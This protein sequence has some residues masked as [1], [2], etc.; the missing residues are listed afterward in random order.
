MPLMNIPNTFVSGATATAA[1]VNA[2]FDHIE[3]THNT[4]IAKNLADTSTAGRI[5]VCNASGVP[6]YAAVSGDATISDTGNLQLAAGSVGATELAAS[7]VG[8][9]D[10]LHSAS[11]FIWNTGTGN[12]LVNNGLLGSAGGEYG[13]AETG[14]ALDAGVSKS[15]PLIFLF[16]AADHALAGRT[17]QIRLKVQILT[18]ATAPGVNFGFFVLPV[19]VTGAANKLNITASGISLVTGATVTTPAASTVSTLVG[20]S[21]APGASG[22]YALTVSMSAAMASNSAVLASSQLQRRYV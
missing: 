14:V 9:W 22:T 8:M 3:T 20:A 16:D 10:T 7:A 21:T 19:T 11:S 13:V 17:L 15:A 5:V 1:G 4:S 2:N 18:N 12:P 6:Q